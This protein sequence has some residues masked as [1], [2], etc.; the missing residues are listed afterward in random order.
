[1]LTRLNESDFT[2]CKKPSASANL[3]GVN[4]FPTQSPIPISPS[5]MFSCRFKSLH[6]MIIIDA[7]SN[8]CRVRSRKVYRIKTA[9]VLSCRFLIRLRRMVKAAIPRYASV[10]P[11]PVGNHSKSTT[12][13]VSSDGS[14]IPA[15]SCRKNASWN[16]Y[17]L[18]SLSSFSVP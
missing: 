9:V 15:I 18:I 6:A 8:C 1:M 2:F 3:L 10:L 14:I 13:L 11:P 7:R 4:P 17:Q 16:G 12:S 5:L